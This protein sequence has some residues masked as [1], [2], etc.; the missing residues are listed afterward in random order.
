MWID[1]VKL[2]VLYENVVLLE[3]FTRCQFL[4][5]TIDIVV[6]VLDIVV[7]LL[8]LLQSFVLIKELWRGRLDLVL[9][10]ELVV[11]FVA[12]DIASQRYHSVAFDVIFADW[13]WADFDL[14]DL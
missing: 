9:D 6:L 8:R 12:L 11:C 13:E 2:T 14:V 1:N 4:R 10:L 3:I 5:I 7:V